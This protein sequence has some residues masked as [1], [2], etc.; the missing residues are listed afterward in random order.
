MAK[1]GKS[2]FRSLRPPCAPESILEKKKLRYYHWAKDPELMRSDLEKYR[3]CVHHLQH[4]YSL[5][6]SDEERWVNNVKLARVSLSNLHYQYS[7]NIQTLQTENEMLYSLLARE[8]Y[9]E[10]PPAMESVPVQSQLIEDSLNQLANYDAQLLSYLKPEFEEKESQSDLPRGNK[11][12]S[13]NNEHERAKV[14]AY[15]PPNPIVVSEPRHENDNILGIHSKLA[16]ALENWKKTGI[17]ADDSRDVEIRYGQLLAHISDL[18]PTGPSKLTSSTHSGC[19]ENEREAFLLV[20]HPYPADEIRQHVRQYL[21]P[22]GSLSQPPDSADSHAATSS[23]SLA[24]AR[25]RRR[26]KPITQR[27]N[28]QSTH[29]QLTALRRT[30]HDQ[31][32]FLTPVSP[33]EDYFG[34]ILLQNTSNHPDSLPTVENLYA[35][36]IIPDSLQQSESMYTRLNQYRGC[37]QRGIRTLHALEKEKGEWTSQLE[38]FKSMPMKDLLETEFGIHPLG[39]GDIPAVMPAPSSGK[40]KES[41]SGGSKKSN[42][43]RTSNSGNIAP[44]EES[45]VAPAVTQHDSNGAVSEV[46]AVKKEE[47]SAAPSKDSKKS[48]ATSKSKSSSA[49][50]KR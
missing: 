47:V 39:E 32:L 22:S 3:N 25:S 27:Q 26:N 9:G 14:L 16:S 13:S 36:D 28:Q 2:I 23:E 12:K 35:S 10:N 33:F 1:N 29:V 7:T 21:N 11:R 37:I 38:K 17:M 4:E 18:N 6:Q 50:K 43:S 8:I 40:S 30:P 49:K 44:V 24:T 48:F 15:F 41:S 34:G 19:L 42:K 45:V 5:L 46:E 20:T 31:P